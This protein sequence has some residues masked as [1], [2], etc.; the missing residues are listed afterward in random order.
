MDIIYQ[1]DNLVIINKPAGIASIP[2][3]DGA[4]Q[5]LLALVQEQLGMKV[6]VVHRLD[7]EVSGAI[8]FAKNED[9]HRDLCR[10]FERR[11]VEK[12]YIA[13]L[14]GIP[15]TDNGEINL[16]LKQFGSGRVGVSPEGKASKTIYSVARKWKF[17]SLADVS[18]ETGRRHQIRAHFYAIGHPVAGDTRYGDKGIQSHF[19]RLMLHS[20]KI[21]FELDG[22]A[23]SA[24][25]PLPQ[26]FGEVLEKVENG[27]FDN[28][29]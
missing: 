7:K 28:L 10:M 4:T 22:E 1:N 21:A 6:F 12:H 23:I 14:H 2:E 24:T 18:I 20:H 19:P 9:A 27:G 3:R 29:Q 8:I 17:Y 15:H 11:D 16:P 25:A 5:N 26:M 13:L